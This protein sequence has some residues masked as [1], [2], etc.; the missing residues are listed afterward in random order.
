[1]AL[2][3]EFKTKLLILLGYALLIVLAGIGILSLYGELQKISE[4]KSDTG[5]REIITVSNVLATLYEADNNGRFLF[6]QSNFYKKHVQDSLIQVMKTDILMLKLRSKDSLYINKLDSVELLLDHKQRNEENMLALMDSIMR[7]PARQRQMITVLSQKDLS[8]IESVI[9]ARDMQIVDSTTVIMQKKSFIQKVSDLFNKNAKDSVSLSYVQKKEMLDSI[10]P[11][12]YTTDTIAQY[13]TDYV[14][15]RNH[16]YSILVSKLSIRQYNLLHTNEVLLNKI[17]YILE[18]LKT[19]DEKARQEIEDSKKEVLAD[20]ARIGY[21]IA[22][23]AIIISI[24]FLALILRLIDRQIQNRKELEQSKTETES[25]LKNKEQLML[26]I[27]H[28][29]KAPL[30]SII[31]FIEILSKLKL[32]E[33]EK[34]FLQNMQISSEQ[35]IELVNN[36]LDSH[37][38]DLG[39]YT[40]NPIN[41][42]PYTLINDICQSF[43]PAA[44][45]KSLKIQLTNK[46][47]STQIYN[48]DPFR[49]KQIVNNLISNA[50]KFTKEGHVNIYAQT[51]QAKGKQWLVVSVEDTGIGISQEDMKKIF[52]QYERSSNSDVQSIEGFGLGLDISQKIAKLLDGYIEVR[53]DLG[54]GSIFTLKIP[55]SFGKATKLESQTNN[56]E[57]RKSELKLL[58]IDDDKVLLNV[59]SE[60]LKQLGYDSMLCDN[61]LKSLELLQNNKYDIVFCDIQ[62]PDMNGFE[63][64]ER[65]RNARFPGAKKIPIVALSARSDVSI[66]TYQEAGFTTFL[67]KPFTSQLLFSVINSLGYNTQNNEV[68]TSSNLGLTETELN[69]YHSLIAFAEDDKDAAKLI[70]NTF[71]NE[72]KKVLSSMKAALK[73]GNWET[74][75]AL[76]HKLLPRMRLINDNE[77]VAILYSLEKGEQNKEKLKTAISM[78]EKRNIDAQKF[79][80]TL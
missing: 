68:E 45:S 57:E 40:L 78:I 19:K 49:I 26:A 22:L 27:S 28:D 3:Q 77:I 52:R 4:V 53:S 14:S 7:L 35:I 66:K 55:I 63:L 48:S 30:S 21:I 16:R 73:S 36:L 32:P 11:V 74:I 2:K 33:K 47:D 34:Y 64:V 24:I 44:D 69:G 67:S 29:I 37:R 46:L 9:R 17:N 61:S 54:K 79:L 72:N 59:Y 8:N 80:K 12:K 58:F 39:Q 31:G 5:N 41:F 62:M 13:M 51:E 75:Q 76:A 56:F 65:I 70:L 10:L 1:M 15:E 42:S 50:L 20:S 71:I 25:L 6:P 43:I 23:A 60:M 18:S 38:L